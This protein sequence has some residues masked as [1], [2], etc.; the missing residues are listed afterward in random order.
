[1]WL[2]SARGSLREF[3]KAHAETELF[4]IESPS[5][6]NSELYVGSARSHFDEE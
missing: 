2:S 4:E 5:Q 6:I 3:T 1:M